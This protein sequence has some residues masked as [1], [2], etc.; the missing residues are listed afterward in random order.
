MEMKG[1]AVLP[2][3]AGLGVAVAAVM[4]GDWQLR[5]AEDKR[6]IQA[7]IEAAATQPAVAPGPAPIAWQ[8][9]RMGGHWVPESAFLLDNR[10][11]GGRPGYH[12]FTVFQP[13]EGLP[14]L[15]N[16]GWLAAGPDRTQLPELA[17]PGGQLVVEGTVRQPEAKPFTLASQPGQ[18]RLWQVLDLP[19]LRD[20]FR[21]PLAD[22]VVFQEG[23]GE[24]GLVRDW[25]RPDTGIDRHRGYAFQWY[26]LAALAAGLTGYF[27]LKQW[28]TRGS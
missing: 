27:G 22:Y 7:R 2:L 6:L 9:I 5:R 10:V 11:H 21:T 13:G 16:R 8:R 14:V 15:V 18:G 25:P 1:V 17:T 20:A 3:V 12:L 24:D 4:L 28:R 23:D 19:A 26:G